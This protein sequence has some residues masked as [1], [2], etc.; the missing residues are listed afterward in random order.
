MSL[1]LVNKGE[2]R[3]GWNRWHIVRDGR[4][5]EILDVEWDE[6]LIRQNWSIELWKKRLEDAVKEAAERE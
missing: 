5:V 6:I 2:L 1:R 3:P 4:V